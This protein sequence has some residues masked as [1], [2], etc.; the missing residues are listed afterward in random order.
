[1][2]RKMLFAALV[3]VSG[4]VLAQP[5]PGLDPKDIGKLPGDMWTTYNGDY[6]GRRF[7][8]LKQITQDSVKQLGLA[9][10]YRLNVGETGAIIGG[11][12]VAPVPN[13]PIIKSVPLMVDGVLYFSAP[14]HA[15]AVDARTGRERWHYFWKTTGGIHIGNRGL[16]M[17]K[18]WL[19]LLTPDDYLVSLDATTGKERWHKQIANVRREY[20]STMAPVVIGDKLLISPGGDSLDVPGFV[21]A[22]NPETGDVIWRWY[23]TP[24]KGDPALATWPSEEAA[25]AGAGHAWL[26][27][28]YDPEL[29]L[30][31]VGTGNPNPVLAGQSR[32]GDNLWTCSIVALDI[33]T[34]KLRWSYQ[35]SPHDTHDFDAVQDV[36]LIDG[37]YNGKPRKLLAQANRTGNFFLLDRVTGEHLLTAPFVQGLNWFKGYNSAGQ[38]MR[39]PGKDPTV[40]GVLVSPFSS[41]ATNWPPTTFSPKTGLFYV[42]ANESFSLFYLTDTD[43]RPQGYGAAEQSVGVIKSSLKAIDYRTGKVVWERPLGKGP[44]GPQSIGAMGLLSTAGGLVFGNDGVGDFVGYRDTDGEPLWHADLA[45]NTSNGP[46]TYMLDGKQ[47]V[48]VGAGDAIYAFALQ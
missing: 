22:R 20:F 12:G 14:D 19:Y 30:Y 40:P 21:E 17:Y 44:S 32:N 7:S 25:I 27:G 35:I 42:G 31:Y 18:N 38:P 37:L 36:V 2:M 45:A 15:W 6:S 33:N 48:L 3:L 5:G 11:E 10:V 4:Q 47:Y 26:P 16:G 1:M 34:G 39:D 28:T 24:R 23:T 13:T 46:T 43:A 9:W 41:G 29:G 8:T